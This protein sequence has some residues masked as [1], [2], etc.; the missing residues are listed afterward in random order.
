MKDRK[1]FLDQIKV[2]DYIAFRAGEARF[3]GWRLKDSCIEE[4]KNEQRDLKRNPLVNEDF[5]PDIEQK[6][7]D[8]KIGLDMAWLASQK[9]V[10]RVLLFS[11]DTDFVPAMKFAR[12]HGLTVAAVQ[13]KS[14]T[15][16]L[17]EHSDEV[18]RVEWKKI[19]TELSG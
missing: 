5:E 18:R 13:M 19:L 17:M 4:I 2:R 15:A 10:E 6:R 9:I 12:E 3:R 7:V 16:S 1:R 8:I 14:T 11:T